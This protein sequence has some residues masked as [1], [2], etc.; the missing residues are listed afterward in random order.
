MG[1]RPICKKQAKKQ[2]K[3]QWYFFILSAS[4]W[5][6]VENSKAILF[7]MYSKDKIDVDIDLMKDEQALYT[8][9]YKIFLREVKEDQNEWR[10]GQCLWIGK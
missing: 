1:V 4:K 6:Q 2:T 5:K 8:E 9:N 7:I 10:D 3:R